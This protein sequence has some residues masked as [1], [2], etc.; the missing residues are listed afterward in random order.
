[1]FVQSENQ[2]LKIRV[3]TDENYAMT[4]LSSNG[5]ITLPKSLRDRLG[6]KV[7]AEIDFSLNVSGE[8]VLKPAKKSLPNAA[9]DYRAALLAV[10]GTADTRFATTDDFMRFV[11]G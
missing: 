9:Q 8:I 5:R 2:H 4:K 7:G 11:R 6:L 3:L 1:M 10:R